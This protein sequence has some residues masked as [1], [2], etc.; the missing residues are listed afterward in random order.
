VNPKCSTHNFVKY[1]PIYNFFHCY[2][3]QKI[4]ITAGQLEYASTAVPSWLLTVWV[5]RWRDIVAPGQDMSW[6]T[7]PFP[8]TWRTAPLSAWPLEV[9]T[10]VD[11]QVAV[12]A[13]HLATQCRPSSDPRSAATVQSAHQSS[14]AGQPSIFLFFQRTTFS[15]ED[16]NIMRLEVWGKVQRTFFFKRGRNRSID[17]ISFWFLLLARYVS[18]AAKRSISV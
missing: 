5:G 7:C 1:W 17:H 2:N 3:L 9:A 13:Y 12:S 4:A 8:S 6:C 18:N 10:S 11:D 14:A 16:S 15:S